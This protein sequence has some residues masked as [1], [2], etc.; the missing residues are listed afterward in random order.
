MKRKLQ[1]QLPKESA[2]S[3]L[4]AYILA[5]KEAEKQAKRPL[6]EREVQNPVDAFLAGVAP[7]LKSLNPLFF[8]E[9][10]S[11]I[12]SIVQEL[13]LKQL[14]NNEQIHQSP[15]S[16]SYLSPRSISTPY[17]SPVE[18]ESSN[19][20]LQSM[21]QQGDLQNACINNQN[22]YSSSAPACSP[23]SPVENNSQSR[24]GMFFLGL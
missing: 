22:H 18:N 6:M 24:P 23:V 2:S 5:E 21:N 13:E 16:Y 4:M 17:I 15:P 10:K 19:A 20:S 14:M 12:F 1:R 7:A 11:K 9:A 8:H 3:Q